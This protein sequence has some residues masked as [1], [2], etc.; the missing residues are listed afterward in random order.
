MK[1]RISASE[2]TGAFRVLPADIEEIVGGFHAEMRRGLAGERSSLKMLPAFVAKPR[3]SETGRYLA[4]DL[5]GTNLRILAVE[6]D[7][8]GGFRVPAADR[9][10]V[11]GELMRG[12][13][14]DLFD[15]LAGRILAFAGKA[16]AGPRDGL[17]LAFTFSFPTEQ[18]RVDAGRLVVWT[19]GFTATGV[20]G[21]DV[22]ELLTR[23]LRRKGAGF[24]RVAAL[25]ND[26]VGTLAAKAYTDRTCDMGVILGTGTNA[27]YVEEKRNIT[28]LRDPGAG[29]EMIVNLEWGNF[30][31]LR[32]TPFD[33]DLDRDS[34]NPGSQLLEKMVSGMYLGELARR[35]IRTMMNDGLLFHGAG[36]DLFT[37]PYAFGTEYLS[38][39]ASDDPG[40]LARF[41]VGGPP[42]NDRALLAEL[43]RVI[44]RRSARIAGAAIAAVLT[45]MDP[46]M[47]RQHTV[48]I[49]GSLFEC[50]PGYPGHLRGALADALGPRADRVR[51]EP[52]KD[53]SGIGAAV[54]AAVADAR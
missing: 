40:V 35:V 1:N 8:D 39:I 54:I 47:G 49:D 2:L 42:E 20:Q 3:G 45:W 36:R 6:L 17:S 18:T 51:L 10:A 5:G 44:V 21:E 16:G 13:G 24:V 46:E 26:T 19:K 37:T 27:C 14:E 50:Y 43:C 7:G 34:P 4:L 11:P 32:R 15:F 29:G 53:G 48:G 52:A 28:R 30:A 9:Y 31:L 22:V 33:E 41:G 38:A 23:S 12:K 25:V